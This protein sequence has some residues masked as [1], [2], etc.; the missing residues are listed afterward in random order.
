MESSSES[1]QEP[2][3]TLHHAE[4]KEHLSTPAAVVS[5]DDPVLLTPGRM[6]QRQVKERDKDK[7]KEA[8][9]QTPNRELVTTPSALSPGVSYT[10]GKKPSE[11]YL[12]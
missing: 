11:D 7:E 4:L 5:G 2:E 3:K 1:Q 6:S 9:L 10:H 8:G 12:E